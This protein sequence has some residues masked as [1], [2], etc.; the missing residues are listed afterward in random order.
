MTVHG[1]LDEMWARTKEEAK[2]ARMQVL[3]VKS[4]PRWIGFES[5]LEG[6]PRPADRGHEA[7]SSERE[8]PA[9]GDSEQA[10]GPG[11]MLRERED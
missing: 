10:P 7:Q 5:R 11:P 6:R 8:C 3:A 4:L 1:Y 9:E 2:A